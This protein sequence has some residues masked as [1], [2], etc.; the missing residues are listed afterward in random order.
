MFLNK[1]V[2]VW[3]CLKGYMYFIGFLLGYFC[4]IFR[5]YTGSKSCILIDFNSYCNKLDK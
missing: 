2:L 1:N 4:I 5:F 3:I